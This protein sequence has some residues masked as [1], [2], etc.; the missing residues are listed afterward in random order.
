M[1]GRKLYEMARAGETIERKAEVRTI[2]SIRCTRFESPEFDL[3]VSFFFFLLLL[4]HF[5]FLPYLSLPTVVLLACLLACPHFFFLCHDIGEV[6]KGH[7]HSDS[8]E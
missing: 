3:T 5:P 4:F 1:G 2:Y 7:V 8:G 6:W